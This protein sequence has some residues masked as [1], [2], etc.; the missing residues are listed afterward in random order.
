MPQPIQINPDESPQA[1]F[2]YELRRQRLRAG[3][4]QLHLAR[5]LTVSVSMVGMLETSRRRPD[6]R[7][8]EACDKIFRLD[9]VFVELWKQTRWESAPEHFRDFAAAEAQASVLQVWD[10]LLIPGLFQ[11]EPYAR[12]IFE[13]EP[14][15]TAE[16]VDQRVANRLQRQALLTST[17]APMVYSLI[18]EGVLHR[19]LGGADIMGEQLAWLLKMAELPR[20]TIQVVPYASWSTLG[21]QASFTVAE[22]RGAPHSAYVESAP[23]G[24]TIGNRET[25]TELVGRFDALRAAAL[26]QNLSLDIIKDVMAQWI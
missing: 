23:R 21:L 26:P 19:P 18:D 25:I 9:G 17:K 12:R 4:T 11:V 24:L 15:I 2:A 6:R 22:Q 14:G 5:M 10:P 3:W 13:D 20:V 7:F 8:A 16:T 1:R